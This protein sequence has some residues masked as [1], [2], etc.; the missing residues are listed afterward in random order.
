[1]VL[2]IMLQLTAFTQQLKLAQKQLN[3]KGK[4][5]FAVPEASLASTPENE[6]SLLQAIS[7]SEKRLTF[8]LAK[9]ITDDYY[10]HNYYTVSFMGLEIV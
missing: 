8:R 6:L 3:E 4:I 5:V 7:S 9:T 1:M 10:R 2:G